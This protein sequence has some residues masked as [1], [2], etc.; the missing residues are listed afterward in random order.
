MTTGTPI[1]AYEKLKSDALEPNIVQTTS[2]LS[3]GTKM[4]TLS[5]Q[6]SSA[7]DWMILNGPRASFYI[8]LTPSNLIPPTS[9]LESEI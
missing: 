3:S 2:L 1:A 9:A 5:A 7:K 4:M 8:P 6:K